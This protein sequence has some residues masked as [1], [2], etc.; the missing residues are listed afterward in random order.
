MKKVTSNLIKIT[1]TLFSVLFFQSVFAQQNDGTIKSE[2]QFQNNDY[3]NSRKQFETKLIKHVSSPQQPATSDSAD[4]P[5]MG[6]SECFFKSGN[7]TLKVWINKPNDTVNK[8]YPLVVF[9]HGG[10]AF[11]KE[12]WD[13]TK[14]FREAGFVVITPMLRSENGQAGNFTFLYDEVND[15]I[16]A[17]EYAR[18]LSFIDDE[19]IYL[20]GHSVGGILALLTSMSYK[21]FKKAVSFSGLPDMLS[22]YKYVIDPNDIPFDT[23]NT[24][25]LKMRSPMAYANSFKCPVRMY[26]GT[27]EP[28][29]LGSTSQQTAAIAKI[30]GLDVKALVVHGGHMSAVEGE[31]KLAINFFNENKQ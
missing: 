2:A 25:E 30:N 26:F 10:L 3:I 19:R 11:G 28:W 29:I 22:N 9:L 23:T 13:M 20:A 8:K 27:E 7:L 4:V 5:P 6:I 1:C 21:H 16:A 12:D 14:P 31:M 17:T 18:H 15:V 24:K